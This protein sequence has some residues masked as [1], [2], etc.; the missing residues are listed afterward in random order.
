MRAKVIRRKR[1]VYICPPTKSKERIGLGL[2]YKLLARSIGAK[3]GDFRGLLVGELR[4]YE[5]PNKRKK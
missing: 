5:D 1:K 2:L 3:A 4:L